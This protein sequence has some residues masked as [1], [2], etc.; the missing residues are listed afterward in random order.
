VILPSLRAASTDKR[1][2]GVDIR[3]LT[4]LHGVLELGEDRVVK[5]WYVA[6]EIGM[7][8]HHV[9]RALKQLVE[10]GYLREGQR[11]E[12]GVRRFRLIANPE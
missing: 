8:R 2:R 5:T 11:Q 6:Q 3:V 7:A 10:F 9:G 1:L 4:Y 12:H